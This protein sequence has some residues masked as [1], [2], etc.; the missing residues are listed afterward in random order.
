MA[1]GTRTR[2][3]RC[4]ERSRSPTRP[5]RR[6]YALLPGRNR[7]F[8]ARASRDGIQALLA[9]GGA[10]VPAGR[11]ALLLKIENRLGEACDSASVPASKGGLPRPRVRRQPGPL[12]RRLRCRL[13]GRPSNAAP[14]SRGRRIGAQ[15]CRLYH[16]RRPRLAL[17]QLFQKYRDC[18]S[19]ARRPG[20]MFG[21]GFLEQVLD[22]EARLPSIPAALTL[23]AR[24]CAALSEDEQA[25]IA[26][27][28]GALGTERAVRELVRSAESSQVQP[29]RAVNRGRSTGS[30][31]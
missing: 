3:Q 24:D 4:V 18:E 28:F 16:R 5:C 29:G 22:L 31:P 1:A 20:R 10:R 2:Q 11:A 13:V 27:Q 6:R 21:Q 8:G 17:P 14:T 23:S 7:P 12:S 19:T 26:Q 9:G 25:D 30:R 15:L